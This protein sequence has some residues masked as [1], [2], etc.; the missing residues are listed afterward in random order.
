M[1]ITAMLSS[2][3]A[4]PPQ[5]S[6]RPS[7]TCQNQVHQVFTSRLSSYAHSTRGQCELVA[8]YVRAADSCIM[9]V[10]TDSK[11]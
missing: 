1:G 11:E 4:D 9:D 6:Q 10:S 5:A 3:F 2:V 7:S 8:L